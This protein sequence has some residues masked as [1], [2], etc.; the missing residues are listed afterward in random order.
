MWSRA[1]HNC[2]SSEPILARCRHFDFS[3]VN[4][5]VAH[6]KHLRRSLW[7]VNLQQPAHTELREWLLLENATT[8][9][10]LAALAAVG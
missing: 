10:F 7:V 5:T 3:A 1:H 4:N 6:R 8:L 2:S 9:G